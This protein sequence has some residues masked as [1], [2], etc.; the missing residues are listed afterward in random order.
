MRAGL[1][2]RV[3][4]VRVA[5]AR[6]AGALVAASVCAVL[7]CAPPDDVAAIS[8]STPRALLECATPPAELQARMWISGS[9]IPCG[10]DVDVDGGST[11]GNCDTRPGVERT[12][13][14]DWF[15]P[16]AGIDLLLAQ[17]RGSVDLTQ[18]EDAEVPFAVEEEDVV[19]TGCVDASVDQVQG[20]PTILVN[21]AQVPVCDV[22]DSC[23]GGDGA[24]TNLGEL[25]A[26]TDPFDPGDEP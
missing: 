24:C 6:V 8:F 16:R 26:A 12:L 25:C 22:D 4:G 20:A 23:A 15:A 5:G 18:G 9:K 14:I 19:T 7:G 2:T 11:S 21:G 13:T 1:G 17:A 3:R 10:L